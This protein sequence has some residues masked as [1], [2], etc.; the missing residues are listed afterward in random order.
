MRGLQQNPRDP[1]DAVVVV[2]ADREQCA[3]PRVAVAGPG[4][5]DGSRRNRGTSGQQK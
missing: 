2:C 4:S 3:R 1:E 5:D